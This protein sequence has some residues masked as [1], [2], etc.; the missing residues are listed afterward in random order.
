MKK[1]A[2]LINTSRGAVIN[3]NDLYTALTDGTLSGAAIDVM[4]KEPPERDNPLLTLDN[5]IIT[6]HAA[7]VSI[8]ARHR[9]IGILCE[10]IRSFIK[11]GNGINKVY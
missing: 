5:C 10:N 2:Y 8:E 4:V 9:M 7:W 1:G 6:P 3:E 11:T